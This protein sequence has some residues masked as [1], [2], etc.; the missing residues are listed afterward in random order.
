MARAKDVLAT[1]DYSKMLRG[2]LS[3]CVKEDYSRTDLDEVV[4][5]FKDFLLDVAGR[6]PR[7]NEAGR[8]SCTLSSALQPPRPSCAQTGFPRLFSIARIKPDLLPLGKSCSR[9]RLPW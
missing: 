9:Q 2:N 6:T 1:R 7:M 3:A 8:E 4:A 5:C